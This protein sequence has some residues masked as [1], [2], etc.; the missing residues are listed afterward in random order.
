MKHKWMM[1]VLAVGLSFAGCG[2]ST[3]TADQAPAGSPGANSNT[4]TAG[5]GG[6]G[7]PGQT[8]NNG[9][10]QAQQP[11]PEPPPEP[12][13]PLVVASGRTIPVI[14][15][16]AVSSYSNK[17]GDPFEGSVASS[18]MVNGEVAIPKG[19]RV[20]GVV[21]DAKKQG[22]FK[23]EATLGIQLT[24]ITVRG[25]PY[26]VSTTP[27]VA[28]EKGKGKRTAVVT[29]GGAAL[30]ALIGGLA[31]GGKGA[32]IGAGVGGGG[33]LAASGATGGKNVNLPSE[34]RIDFALKAPIEIERKATERQ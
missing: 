14:L 6:T 18:V 20:S 31:G 22:K 33:G 8:G 24:R 26:D 3:N 25:T 32:A 23:G 9:S 27:Y 2:K 34:T 15:T 11:A 1:C 17:E 28:T 7:Q 10:M 5:Q 12:P 30:G 29:G 13:K 4:G 16:T 19:S 21:I